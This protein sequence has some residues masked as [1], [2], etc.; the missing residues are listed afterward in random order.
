M[1]LASPSS[2]LGILYV[3]INSR[4]QIHPV[5]WY[6]LC[7]YSNAANLVL[8]HYSCFTMCN[9]K[10]WVTWYLHSFQMTAGVPHW[11]KGNYAVFTLKALFPELLY[12]MQQMLKCGWSPE[13]K[14][15]LEC[16]SAPNPGVCK[17]LLRTILGSLI[18]TED[19]ETFYAFVV[20][21]QIMHLPFQNQT[22][23]NYHW[24]IQRFS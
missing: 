5:P 3:Y 23:V 20:I 10:P 21:G 19:S 17:I 12:T 7:W 6:L 18:C 24:Y 13:N 2:E 8:F 1:N 22:M 4:R 15:L 11:R 9:Q 14:E 16:P